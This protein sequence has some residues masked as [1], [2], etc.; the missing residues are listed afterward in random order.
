MKNGVLRLLEPV[1]GK[2][3]GAI[4][5]MQNPRAKDPDAQFKAMM[6][7]FTGTYA[8]RPA[9][10]KETQTIEQHI[11]LKRLK[12]KPER[13]L[14]AYCDDLMANGRKQVGGSSKTRNRRLFSPEIISAGSGVPRL[15]GRTRPLICIGQTDRGAGRPR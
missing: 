15:R 6:H 14:V 4:F 1:N 11:P 10:M 12:D 3:T 9:K 13:A 2:V 7:D 8:N 5:M